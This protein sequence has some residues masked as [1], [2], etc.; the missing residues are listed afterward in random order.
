MVL[1]KGV[2]KYAKSNPQIKSYRSG[3]EHEGGKGV[4]IVYFK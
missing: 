1:K 4:T 3:T 2:E